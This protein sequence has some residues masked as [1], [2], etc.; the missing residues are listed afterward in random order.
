MK[1]GL[2]MQLPFGKTGNNAV[3]FLAT[4]KGVDPQDATAVAEMLLAL[5]AIETAAVLARVRAAQ[6][7][8]EG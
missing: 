6:P 4:M 7:D 2:N 5:V 8:K 3:K 1:E